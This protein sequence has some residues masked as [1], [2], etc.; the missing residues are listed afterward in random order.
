MI[1]QDLI[2]PYGDLA[3]SAVRLGDRRRYQVATA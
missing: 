2:T 3:S 1:E